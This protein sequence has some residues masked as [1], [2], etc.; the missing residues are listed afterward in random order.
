MWYKV[1]KRLIG[2]NQV[3][4]SWW[5][6]WS[7]TIAYFPLESDSTDI[8]HNV[9]LTSYWTT[10]YTTV[11]WVKSAEFTKSNWLY[12]SNFSYVPQWDISK[13]LSF[14]M[15]IKWG[16]GWWQG[17]AQIWEN[18]AWKL[19][20]VWCYNWTSLIIMTR[21]GST[22]WTYTPTLNTRTNMVATYS[23][24]T[25][26][27]YANWVLQV[28]WSNT[29]APTSWYNLYIWQNIWDTSTLLTYYWNLSKV[30][31]ES[32][33]RTATQVSEYYNQTKSNYWL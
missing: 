25:W 32:I 10:N 12:N 2:T 16:N 8:I 21:Y 17:I 7:N 27:L 15:Y 5:Q 11:W 4:P 33:P 22:S 14:W 6:P 29:T 9:S 30:I 24:S 1:N 26:K 3:R 28:T 18:S 23:N 19:F 13:T 31:F 20:W